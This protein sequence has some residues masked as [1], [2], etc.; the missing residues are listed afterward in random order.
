[1][2]DAVKTPAPPVVPPAESVV[3]PAPDPFAPAK[4]DYPRHMH[5]RGSQPIVVHSDIQQ[6]KGKRSGYVLEPADL[7]AYPVVLEHLDAM[8]V[9]VS[10]VTA[11]RDA[12]A[13]GYHRKPIY[14][15]VTPFAGEQEPEPVELPEPTVTQKP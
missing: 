9:T 10:S 7:P 3:P 5:R 4:T 15:G 1:M 2:T 12:L 8:D 13:H 6:V 14:S 11:E